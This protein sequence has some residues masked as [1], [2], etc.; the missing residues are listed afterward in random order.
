MVI[1]QRKTSISLE[2]SFLVGLKEIAA[3]EG[4][5]IPALITCIDTDRQQG[6]LSSTVRLYVLDYYRRLA[7]QALAAGKGKR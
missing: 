4:I 7:E 2:A 5:S 6:N 1:G 3:R